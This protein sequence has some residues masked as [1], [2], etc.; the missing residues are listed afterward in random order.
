MFKQLRFQNFKSWQ[1]TGDIKL[2]PITG[3][4]GMNSSGKSAI[5]QFLLMLKQTME[6]SVAQKVESVKNAFISCTGFF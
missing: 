5:L 6:S 3:F 4:F 1:D 2:S